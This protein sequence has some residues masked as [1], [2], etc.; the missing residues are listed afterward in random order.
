MRREDYHELA[1]VHHD[2]KA[3]VYGAA[4]FGAKAAGHRDRARWHAS[5]GAR[6][7]KLP[8]YDVMKGKYKD[9]SLSAQSAP[10]GGYAGNFFPTG[11]PD[12]DSREHDKLV[13]LG[14]VL[15][16]ASPN[17]KKRRQRFGSDDLGDSAPDLDV[18]ESDYVPG[19]DE[20][21]YPPPNTPRGD[22]YRGAF[23]DGL[24]GVVPPKRP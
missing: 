3:D 16:H 5:F 10:G 12:L 21:Y 4:G 14:G 23:H 6:K 18:P 15:D 22:T 20:V 8:S 11:R 7:P 13:R 17:P 24:A 2:A 9:W 1:T 19:S